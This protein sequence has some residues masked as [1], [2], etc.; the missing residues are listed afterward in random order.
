MPVVVH[1]RL[2][3]DADIS[4]NAFFP[5]LS[6]NDFQKTQRIDSKVP[7]ELLRDV[8]ASAITRIQRA[9]LQWQ[10]QKIAEGYDELEAVPADTIGK[11]SVLVAAYRLAVYLRAKGELLKHYSHYDLTA[12]GADKAEHSRRQGNWYLGE[13]S[14]QLR[15]LIGKPATR[16]SSL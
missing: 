11:E 8:L 9:A 12:K 13:A 15:V 6:L 2:H 7:E 1:N 16:V 10:C 3:A 14:K 4:G 5:V